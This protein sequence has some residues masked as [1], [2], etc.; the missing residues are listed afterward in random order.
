MQPGQNEQRIRLTLQKL[1]TPAQPPLRKVIRSGSQDHC[2]S[3]RHQTHPVGSLPERFVREESIDAET[4]ADEIPT[5]I[6]EDHN[7]ETG[8][9]EHRY[10][11]FAAPR[12]E[13]SHARYETFNRSQHEDE[14][15]QDQ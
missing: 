15:Q 3:Q 7:M 4:E 8:S 10:P 9:H 6:E 11:K 14:A 12:N 13:P 1:P 5:T 2:I